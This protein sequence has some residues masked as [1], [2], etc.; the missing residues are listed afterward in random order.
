M[1]A[2]GV[3]LLLQTLPHQ[4]G[5]GVAIVLLGALPGGVPQLLLRP[6]DAGGVGAPWDGPDVLSI[7]AATLLGLVTTIS[8]AFSGGR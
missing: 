7:M 5:Q 1:A 4:V 2:D 6:L 3:Q 8:R